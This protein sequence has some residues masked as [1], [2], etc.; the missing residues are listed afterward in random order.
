LFRTRRKLLKQQLEEQREHEQDMLRRQ[1]G[2][3]REKRLVKPDDE[4]KRKLVELLHKVRWGT[5]LSICYS[6][7]S[8]GAHSYLWSRTP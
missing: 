8:G 5:Q 4:S 3:K 7:E 1:A 6:A 2:G